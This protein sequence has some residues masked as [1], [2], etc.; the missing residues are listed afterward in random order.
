MVD[1][2]RLGVRRAALRAA[3]REDDPLTASRAGSRLRLRSAS[4]PVAEIAAARAARARFGRV[5]REAR[6]R[7][8]LSGPA[9]IAYVGRPLRRVPRRAHL[10]RVASLIAALAAIAL[11]AVLLIPP[12]A[13]DPG[14]AAARAEVVLAPVV[15]APVIGGRGR[16]TLAVVTLTE[17][18]PTPQPTSTPE[19]A[20]TPQPSAEPEPT[21]APE[22]SSVATI[23]TPDPAA[24]DPD[25]ATGPNG[26]GTPGGLGSEPGGAVG[27]E[28]GPTGE[29]VRT[30]TPTRAPAFTPPPLA[31]GHSRLVFRT[32]DHA[33][34]APL[35]DVCIVLDGHIC[36]PSRPHTSTLGLWWMDLAPD[37][38]VRSWEFTF[39]LAGYHPVQAIVAFRQHA[40][41]TID[42]R[43]RRTQ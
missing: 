27:V 34:G 11:L 1:D 8:R 39:E 19:P 41:R 7:R 43:L 23:A 10:Q 32:T 22:P 29:P 15:A 5:V 30:A 14:A 9:S 38:L 12:P 4:L 26:G 25:G 35:A 28:P 36:E 13:D 31:L 42:V 16:T 21:A 24:G 3:L 37:A 2:P 18:S 17:P 20:A 6:W 40:E 33:T